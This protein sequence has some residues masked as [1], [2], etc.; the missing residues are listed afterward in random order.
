MMLFRM[1]LFGFLFLELE[2]REEM[3]V[4]L[5]LPQSRN[6]DTFH[7]YIPFLCHPDLTCCSRQICFRLSFLATGFF[8]AILEIHWKKHYHATQMDRIELMNTADANE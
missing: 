8:L 7:E 5:F 3:G 2:M 1:M 6:Q 4:S